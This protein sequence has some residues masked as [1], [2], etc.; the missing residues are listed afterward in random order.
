MEAVDT[1]GGD[2]GVKPCCEALGLSRA[3][4]YRT[5]ASTSLDSHVSFLS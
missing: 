4:Y 3:T 2:I 1:F 5:R